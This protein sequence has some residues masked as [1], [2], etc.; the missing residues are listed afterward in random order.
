MTNEFVNIENVE[1]EFFHGVREDG[2][3]CTTSLIYP[4]CEFLNPDAVTVA[5]TTYH[6]KCVYVRSKDDGTLSDTD[7]VGWTKYKI[8]L[9]AVVR[10]RRNDDGTLF[11]DHIIIVDGDMSII[12]AGP[13]RPGTPQPGYLTREEGHE[14]RNFVHEYP[15]SRKY[16]PSPTLN[17]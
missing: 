1:V 8:P 12:A 5:D 14:K 15:P 3:Y 2:D 11:A 9:R 6:R 13:H 10:L 16:T 17:Q 7:P 4:P